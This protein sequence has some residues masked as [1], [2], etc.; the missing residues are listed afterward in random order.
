MICIDAFKNLNIAYNNNQLAV[1]PCCISPTKEATQIDFYSNEYLIDIRDTW[2]KHEFP[3][4][5]SSCK[6]NRSNR[7]HGSNKWYADNGYNNT[8]VELI[9]LDYWTGDTCN[10][11]CAICGPFNSSAWRQELDMPLQ[12]SA[13][14]H[15]WKTLDLTTLKFVHFNGGEPLLSKEHVLFLEAIP[16]KQNVHLVYNTNGTVRASQ[17]LRSL[18]EQFSLV[19]LDFSIDDINERFEYQ[20][21]PANWAEVT[22]NLQWYIE[23]SPVNCMFAVN[24]TVSVLNVSNVDNLNSWLDANFYINR[25]SDPIERRTQKA[26]GL[27]AL[28]TEKIKSRYI[29]EFLDRCDERRGTNWRKTFPELAESTKYN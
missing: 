22:S 27:F 8:D 5:C 16:N 17:E 18:W 28:E 13:S 21:Y 11:R 6:N 7:M 10:L 3:A 1:S 15:F 9:R 2:A 24:T 20:R 12:K 19:K 29:V 25:I 26:H 4:A 23:N 14:N